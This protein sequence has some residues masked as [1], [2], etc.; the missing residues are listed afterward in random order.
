MSTNIEITDQIVFGEKSI[1]EIKVLPLSFVSFSKIWAETQ[2][3]VRAS[4]TDANGSSIMQRKRVIL[5]AQ[6]MAGSD[7][8]KPEIANILQ[9]PLKVAKQIIAA[10]D[11]GEGVAGSLL[12]DGDG[13]S[14]PVHYK[15]GSPL[16]LTVNGKKQTIAELEFSAKVYGDVEDVL[17][18][19]GE[20]VQALELIKRCAQPIGL[21]SNITTLPSWALERMTVADGVT[22]MRNVLP[23]F[24]E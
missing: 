23:R 22:I 6:F 16:S 11:V 7:R 14:S 8:I 1:T 3:E 13:I 5:Q 12:N 9:L 17:A 10:L 15:L 20:V 4:R 19:D 18:A 2:N 24:L 21:D